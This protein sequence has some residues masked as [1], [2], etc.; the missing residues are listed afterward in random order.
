MGVDV[1]LVMA[2]V[3]GGGRP[4]CGLLSSLRRGRSGMMGF[5]VCWPDGINQRGDH[6][7]RGRGS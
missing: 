3:P 7:T 1:A 2:G 5:A 4:R 6:A